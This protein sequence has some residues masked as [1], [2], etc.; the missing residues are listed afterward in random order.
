VPVPPT[1]GPPARRYFDRPDVMA[2]FVV[3]IEA[4]QSLP[5]LLSNGNKVRRSAHITSQRVA[6][7]RKCLRTH[8]QVR[9]HA[10]AHS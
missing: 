7:T 3:R 6:R 8:S 2:Q 5:I 4:D 10:R 1:A 9:T